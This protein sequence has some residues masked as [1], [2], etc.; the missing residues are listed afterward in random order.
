MHF[1]IKGW[2]T[3]TSYQ[4]NITEIKS[5]TKF[6]IGYL[7][8]IMLATMLSFVYTN[9]YSVAGVASLLTGLALAFYLILLASGRI[10]N[11][12]WGLLTT[13]MW[14]IIS[15]HNHL[16]GDM[17]NQGFFFVMQ[18]VGMYAWQKQLE[19]QADQTVIESKKLSWIQL[20][21]S[22]IG[23]GLIYV[24]VLVIAK[25]GHG[26]QYYLDSAQLPLGV[27]A[28]VLATYGYFSSWI[29]WLAVDAVGLLLWWNQIQDGGMAAIGMF[30]LMIVKTFNAFYGMYLWSK[31][32]EK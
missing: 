11:F 19:R 1:F 13:G 15:V 26:N 29:V 31:N 23:S 14:F 25:S 32:P 28:Q 5:F 2:K 17:I 12:F 30:I 16:I 6:Q 7:I 20:V 4:R 8:I 24:V 18:F 3:A 10:T 22:A 21:C 27:L 9:D